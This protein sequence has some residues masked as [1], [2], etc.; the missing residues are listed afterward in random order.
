LSEEEGAPFLYTG[1]EMDK[2][3]LKGFAHLRKLEALTGS[4]SG[5]TTT[6]VSA[7]SSPR[8][9]TPASSAPPCSEPGHRRPRDLRAVALS[10]L[11]GRVGGGALKKDGHEIWRRPLKHYAW[12]SPTAV[13]DAE[14]HTYFLQ[15]DISGR[16]HLIDARTG[17]IVD[18][19]LLD[20]AVESS[21]SVFGD[22]AVI[23]TRGGHIWG[24]RLE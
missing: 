4:Q 23:G 1:C 3:G 11:R 17:E 16:I 24:I 21:P 18:T 12:P 9:S 6:R 19:L 20:G 15:G 14:G 13:K 10:G 8:R 7:R 5:S 2:Q 22:M